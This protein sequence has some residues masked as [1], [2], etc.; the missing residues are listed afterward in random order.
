MMNVEIPPHKAKDVGNDIFGEE[1]LQLAKIVKTALNSSG[2]IW[3][4]D[5]GTL[6][7]AYRNGKFIHHDD[8][9][10]TAVYFAN[11]KEK[12]LID[13]M[14]HIKQELYPPYDIRMVTSYASKLEIFDTTSRRYL[15]PGSEYK[16]AD[17][18]TVTVDIQVM[19]DIDDSVI[20]LHDL[21]RHL[22]IPKESIQPIG[23][24]MCEGVAFN[25]PH[26]V[27]E[28]LKA[29]IGYLGLNA[30]FDSETRKYVKIE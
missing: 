18:H 7:G 1:R 5:G 6:L 11:Y 20:S 2:V 29:Q 30:R 26:L 23:K 14:H 10:D 24:I 15:L 17:F 3:F 21:L 19:T 16:G 9:F 8:D 25:C 13:L 4:L 22:K 27:E 12:E 28:Y